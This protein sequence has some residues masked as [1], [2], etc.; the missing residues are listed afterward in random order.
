MFL[1][2]CTV[3]IVINSTEVKSNGQ[4]QYTKLA[5]FTAIVFKNDMLLEYICLDSGTENHFYILGNNN[6]SSCI[7]LYFLDPFGQLPCSD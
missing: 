1:H 2:A 3:E 7:Y 5:H 6:L 4:E